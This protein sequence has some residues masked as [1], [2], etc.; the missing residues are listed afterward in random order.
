MNFWDIIAA[1]VYVMIPLAIL[2]IAT[3]WIWI[4]RS[5]S[6][7]RSMNSADEIMH[8]LRDYIVE[9]DIENAAKICEGSDVPVGRIVR[10]GVERIGSP[11]YEVREA[12]REEEALESEK[13]KRGCRWIWWIAVIS[14]LLGLGGTLGGMAVGFHILE[15]SGLP[16]D[17][18]QF[19]G[20]VW[21]TLITLISGL[22]V[23][24]FAL[25]AHTVLSGNISKTGLLL[26]DY[27]S[28]FIDLLN[29]PS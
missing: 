25:T 3:V 29:E 6:I 19:T 16:G 12:M 24:I 28:R 18:A 26:S 20:I 9:G 4:A 17:F 27:S 21:P 14:P 7:G 1:G 15:N 13:L 10:R 23:G 22:G 5:S 2:L 11:M 8:R